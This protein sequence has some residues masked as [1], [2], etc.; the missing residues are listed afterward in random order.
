[1]VERCSTQPASS[2]LRPDVAARNKPT[3]AVEP[4]TSDGQVLLDPDG[5]AHTIVAAGVQALLHLGWR[6]A[7]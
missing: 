6:S 7:D 3:T 5:D 2:L 1:M 4:E